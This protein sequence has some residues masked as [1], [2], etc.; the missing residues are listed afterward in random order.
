MWTKMFIKE[1]ILVWRITNFFLFFAGTY[2]LEFQR[3][4]YVSHKIEWS[5]EMIIKFM[6]IALMHVEMTI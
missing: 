1:L 2:I 6:I 4:S 5:T 3:P